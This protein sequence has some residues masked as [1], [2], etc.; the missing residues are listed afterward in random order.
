MNAATRA[1]A[2]RLHVAPVD[3]AIYAVAGDTAMRMVSVVRVDDYRIAICDC[4]ATIKC[5]HA[6]A[7]IDLDVKAAAGGGAKNY[8]DADHHDLHRGGP[9]DAEE[10]E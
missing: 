1:K 5:S 10:G 2:A 4:P 8:L 7:A 9:L 6:V 3:G